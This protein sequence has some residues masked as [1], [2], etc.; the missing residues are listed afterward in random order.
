[1]VP[2]PCTYVT[3]HFS[4]LSAAETLAVV[5]VETKSKIQ[6]HQSG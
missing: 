3:T 2:D 5:N 6:K 1:V 4:T